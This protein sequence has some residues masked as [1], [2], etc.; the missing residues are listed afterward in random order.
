MAGEGVQ[1]GERIFVHTGD[2][3]LAG[4]VWWPDSEPLAGVVLI[5]GS[6]AADRSNGGYFVPYRDQFTGHG[7]AV[8][9]YDK[10]GVGEST[11]SWLAGTLDDLAADAMAAV[12]SLQRMLGAVPVGLFGHSEGG[13][14]ALR[15]AA[16]SAG[17]SFVV[18]NSCPGTTPGQQDRHAVATAMTADARPETEQ[19]AALRLYDDLADAAARDR[20]YPYLQ[21]L[22][23]SS[24]GYGILR[25]YIASFDETAWTFFKREHG[26]DP[27]PDCL[28]LRCPHLAIFGSADPLVPVEQSVVAFTAAACATSR[29]PEAT[30]TIHIVPGAGHRLLK[31]S[32]A[33]PD[34]RH[35]A[36]LCTWIITATANHAE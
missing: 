4:D 13:W 1:P 29:H 17:T 6:G 19:A 9:W 26:H 18:T 8:L 10:R 35:L 15:A 3:V 16:Q 20:G 27:I 2:V 14:V 25:E 21:Q 22:F 30:T 31:K 33:T 7:I 11:G 36:N 24:P 5:G 23:A 32:S 28:A 34:G 12:S